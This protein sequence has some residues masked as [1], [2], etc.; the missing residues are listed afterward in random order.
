[1]LKEF[2]ITDIGLEKKVELE[3]YQGLIWVRPIKKLF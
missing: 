3:D 2:K 1:M